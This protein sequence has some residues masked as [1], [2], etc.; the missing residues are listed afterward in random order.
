MKRFFCSG[1]R[2]SRS[3]SA[4]SSNI[5]FGFWFLYVFLLLASFQCNLRAIMTMPHY[6][7]EVDNEVDLLR[8]GKKLY[9]PRGTHHS[10]LFKTSPIAVQRE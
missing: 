5:F 8:S 9:A 6:E 10:L 7:N 1:T 4:Y 3:N 2:Y